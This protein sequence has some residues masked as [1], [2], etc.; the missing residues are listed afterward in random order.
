[1]KPLIDDAVVEFRRLRKLNQD[2][3][4]DAV[5]A[6]LVAHEMAFQAAWA[7]LPGGFT[8]AAGPLAAHLKSVRR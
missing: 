1:V 8:A 3:P 5:L 7:L 4:G 2:R 6:E